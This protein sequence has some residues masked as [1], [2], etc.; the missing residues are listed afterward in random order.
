MSLDKAGP[1]RQLQLNELKEIRNDAYENSKISK[2]KMKSVHDQHILRKIFRSW[3]KSPSIQFLI[4][5][6]SRKA[7]K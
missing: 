6:I 3:S 7:S 1:L 2:V 4:A 5:L